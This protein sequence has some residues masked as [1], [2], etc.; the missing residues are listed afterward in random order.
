M[1]K[2]KVFGEKL[3]VEKIMVEGDFGKEEF[4]NEVIVLGIGESAQ[5]WGIKEGDKLKIAGFSEYDKETYVIKS[6]ILRWVC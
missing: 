5:D 4:K 2:I 1:K 6:Q 3:L